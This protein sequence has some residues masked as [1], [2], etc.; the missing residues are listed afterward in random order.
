M[1][2][3]TLRERG[4]GSGQL[5]EQTGARSERGLNGRGAGCVARNAHILVR[6]VWLGML[7]YEEAQ[8]L[9]HKDHSFGGCATLGLLVTVVPSTRDGVERGSD[10]RSQLVEGR[11]ARK[12]LPGVWQSLRAVGR[13]GPFAGA[14]PSG[15]VGP[16]GDRVG[17]GHSVGTVASLCGSF[18]QNFQKGTNAGQV[19]DQRIWPSLPEGPSKRFCELGERSSIE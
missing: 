15:D 1:A 13:E 18:F 8:Q 10:D 14:G 9:W 6:G 19:D 4:A 16:L 2:V 7:R 12:A 5:Q 3:R 17:G 11:G